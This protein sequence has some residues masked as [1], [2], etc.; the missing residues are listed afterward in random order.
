MNKS[1]FFDRDGVIN[2]DPGDYTFE[3]DEFKINDGILSSLKKLYDKGYLLIIITNQGGISKRLY[4][5]KHVEDIHHYLADELKKVDVELTEIYYCPHHSIN[6]K[7]ICR[8]PN[9]LMIEKAIARFN[10]NPKKSF[11]IGDKMRDVEAAENAGIKGI[12]VG[13]NENIE[14]L[15]DEIIQ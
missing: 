6:E 3:L 13:L 1:A 7:C 12:K 15:I 5:H 8:K 10:I 4:T 2:F 11:M 14:N 9:S